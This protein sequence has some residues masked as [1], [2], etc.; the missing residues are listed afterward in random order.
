MSRPPHVTANIFMLFLLLFNFL[1]VVVV[2]YLHWELGVQLRSPWWLVANQ[3]I[4]LLLPMVIFSLLTKGVAFL[5]GKRAEGGGAGPHGLGFVNL[6]LVVILSILLQPAMMLVSALASLVIPNPVTGLISELAVLPLPAAIIIVALT[7]AICEELVFRG[8]IQS[9]YEGQPIAVTA[10]VNG[11]F[12]GMVH[13]NLHQFTY[14]FLMGIVF[15]YMVY[16]TRSVLAAIVGHFVVNAVQYVLG[17]LAIRRDGPMVEVPYAGDFLAVLAG[18]GG[19]VAF[20]LPLVVMLFYVFVKYNVWRRGPA[21]EVMAA[22]G[23]PFGLAFWAVVLVF[24][25]LILN[26]GL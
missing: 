13:M 14:A 6:I 22:D 8:F 17:Y 3:V 11:L 19:I 21:E 2:S 7:P 15:A 10:F 5:E 24:G 9:R 4:G 1:L 23:H 26:F 12:F 20:T 18:L 16:Y 25:V